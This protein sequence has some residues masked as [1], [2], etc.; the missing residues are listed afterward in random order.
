MKFEN[1]HYFPFSV[2]YISIF[3]RILPIF[4]NNK[5]VNLM[6]SH[7]GT[8]LSLQ[9]TSSHKLRTIDFNTKYKLFGSKKRIKSDSH[10]I[11]PRKKKRRSI[12]I[13]YIWKMN[14]RLLGNYLCST[15]TVARSQW[16]RA[17][18]QSRFNAENHKMFICIYIYI[19]K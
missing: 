17:H 16:W 7:D 12:C 13:F 14:T 3:N 10:W 1:V 11:Y 9:F 2:H 8:F 18:K 5:L 19:F 4:N 15:H 6:W